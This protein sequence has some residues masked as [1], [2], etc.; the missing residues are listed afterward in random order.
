MSRPRLRQKSLSLSSLV[1][2]FVEVVEYIFL[3]GTIFQQLEQNLSFD[4]S[5]MGEDGKALEPVFGPGLTGLA[6]MGNT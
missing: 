3:P 6:N 1:S 5:M 4:F 2:L